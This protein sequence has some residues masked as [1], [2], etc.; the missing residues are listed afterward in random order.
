MTRTAPPTDVPPST[1]IVFTHIPKTAGSSFVADLV[2]ANLPPDAVGSTSPLRSLRTRFEPGQ[3]FLTGHSAFGAH[4]LIA[5]PVVYATFL[6]EPIDR[7]VSYYYFVRDPHSGSYRHPE[8]NRAER[9]SLIEFTRHRSRRNTQARYL[10]GVVCD[11]LYRVL[12]VALADR[13]VL[14]YASAH[15]RDRYVCIGLQ[16]RYE[17]SIA[18]FQTAFGWDRRNPNPVRLK[19]TGERPA[20]AEL[21]PAIVAELHSILAVDREVYRLAVVR[22]E[23]LLAEPPDFRSLCPA[24]NPIHADG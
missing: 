8:R 24:R 9:M 21:S 14:R 23:A 7:A 19:R 12:P 4:R 10:A 11:R 1:A 2:E 16:S 6:R 20:V 5:S 22:F 3:R 18:L 13:L 17:E 15:L